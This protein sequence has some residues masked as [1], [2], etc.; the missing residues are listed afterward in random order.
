MRG[1]AVGAGDR[2]AAFQ[3]HQFGQHLGA[4]HHRN[5]LGARRHQFGIVALDRGRD[6]DDV[7]AVDILGVVADRNLDALLAQP[8][9]I[10]DLSDASEPCTV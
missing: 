8:V 9:E 7:G 1:L 10:A 6:H 5:A 4:P 3:P 2:D